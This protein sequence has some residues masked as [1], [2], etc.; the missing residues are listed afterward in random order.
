MLPAKNRLTRD[1]D[2]QRVATKGRYSY[3]P[4]LTV[5]YYPNRLPVSRFGFVISTKIDKRAVVRNRTKRQVREVI[6]LR[7]AN[8]R[9]GMD[10][11]IIMK[12]ASVGQEMA[13]LRHDLLSTL[14]KAG[15]YVD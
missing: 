15:L 6:R 11:V 12:K 14:D 8:V 4:L 13:V 2:F 5:K 7:L 10:I 1:Q 3:S 9:T